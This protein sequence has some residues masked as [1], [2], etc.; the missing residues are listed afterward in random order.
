MTAHPAVPPEPG[1][2]DPA[3]AAPTQPLPDG[4]DGPDIDG[5]AATAPDGPTAPAEPA[6]EPEPDAGGDAQPAA[7]K[8]RRPW[9]SG[10]QGKPRRKAPWWE[11]PALVALAIV[12]AILVKTFL[13][14]PFY[15]PS[16]SMER[17]LHG[18][19]GCS[20]D[21]ILVNK[22]IY[23]FRDPHPGD[24]VVFNAP[25]GWDDE[26]RS[27]PPSNPV[28]RVVR[29]FGQLIGFVP[30]DG[31]IL[32]KRV[33]AVGGQTVK[34]DAQGHVFISDHG[35]NGPWRELDEPYVYRPTGIEPQAKFG[36]V[37]VPAGRLWVLGDHRDDSADSRF[38]CGP[39]GEDD[40]DYGPHCDVQAATVPDGDV[41]GKA[42]V[43]AWP[44][45]RWRTLGTP[46]TFEAAGAG[47]VG[48]GAVP[49]AIVAP[50]FVI[51]R[52][53]RRKRRRART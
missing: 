9:R 52:R 1:R 14:Q 22:V 26:P 23:D 47:L 6:A 33:I 20:G 40:G 49:V 8:A 28:L 4:P 27:T 17:T 11:L 30:P 2:P 50:V 34:G 25:P 41:I 39:G 32:V 15:I 38:H 24:I 46:A 31:M 53:R 29:G 44:P 36:P 19:P 51:V 48:T 37:T 16:G 21:R 18:C 35:P 5:P 10:R 45:S 42:F 12:I 7:T 3:E 13:V 43:I